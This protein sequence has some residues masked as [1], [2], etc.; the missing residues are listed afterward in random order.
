MPDRDVLYGSGILKMTSQRGQMSYV[1]YTVAVLGVVGVLA[2][3]LIPA[4]TSATR[5]IV[6]DAPIEAVWAIYT[7]PARQPDW[8][9]GVGTVSVSE[10][11]QSWIE[12]LSPSGMTIHFEILEKTRPHR[13]VLRT[14]SPNSFTGRYTAVF[15]KSGSGTI[16]TFTEESTAS[17]LIP[18]VMKFVFVNQVAFIEKYA[19]EA[20]EEIRRRRSQNG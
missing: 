20:K 7:E 8:R 13:L 10:D 1:V 19:E 14:S 3:I 5:S 18:K 17:R 2:A 6:F 15:V 9:S 11:G 12:T 4:T 16:G